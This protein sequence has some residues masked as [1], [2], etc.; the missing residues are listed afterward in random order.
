MNRNVHV[1]MVNR[2]II[3]YEVYRKEDLIEETINVRVA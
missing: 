3:K 1:I 2:D